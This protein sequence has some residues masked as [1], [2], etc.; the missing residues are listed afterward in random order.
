[1]ETLVDKLKAHLSELGAEISK[2]ENL[3]HKDFVSGAVKKHAGDIFLVIDF[4]GAGTV[5]AD[6]EEKVHLDKTIKRLHV[7]RL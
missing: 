4:S 7:N 5:P 3:G 1:M 2:V 6:L